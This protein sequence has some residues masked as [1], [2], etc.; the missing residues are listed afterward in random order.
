MREASLELEGV[1]LGLGNF[2]LSGI[3]L[4]VGAG[5]LFVLLGPSGAGKTVLLETIAGFHRPKSGA[6]R[7]GG[8]DITDEAL[9]RRRVAFMFQDYAL[10]P[11]LTVRGNIAFGLSGKGG[12]ASASRIRELQSRLGLDAILDRKPA[13]LSG[14]EKQRVALARAMAAEPELFLFDEPLS[15][16]DAHTRESLRDELKRFLRELGIP[17]IFVT[18][19]QTEAQVLADRLAIIREGRIVQVGTPA[20]IFNAPADEFVASFVGMENV[21]P[22]RV[23]S[24]APEGAKIEVKEG[25]NIHAVLC[26]SGPGREV[27]VCVRPEDVSLSSTTRPISGPMAAAVSS[28]SP[29]RF[30]GLVT[31]IEA[32]GPVLNIGIDC[33][34]PLSAYLTRQAFSDLGLRTGDR[35]LAA[36]RAE[37][38]HVIE[39]HGS[40]AA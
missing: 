30:E 23:L 1:A 29:N 38:V 5:E 33:G 24:A 21:I 26:A 17:A 18:H 37:A 2:S 14:G 32:F 20:G 15:A 4:S 8:R 27:F 3:D 22:G 39:R 28:K 19:D 7:L 11:H 40:G 9:E 10:F 12:R 13:G 35:V 36:F 31:S 34:F 16:L 25:R 6:I